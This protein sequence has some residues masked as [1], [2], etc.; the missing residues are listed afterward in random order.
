MIVI[1]KL[2]CV[3]DPGPYDPHEIE[4]KSTIM[5]RDAVSIVM[6]GPNLPQPIVAIVDA[7]ELRRAITNALNAHAP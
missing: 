6:D 7:E 3:C 1:N 4:V 5:R 2:M